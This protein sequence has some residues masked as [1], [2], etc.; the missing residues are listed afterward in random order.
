MAEVTTKPLPVV[1]TETDHQ[2]GI[3]AVRLASVVGRTTQLSDEARE[4]LEA[5]ER[6]ASE[7]LGQLWEE[8]AGT[9]DVA[10]KITKVRPTD[11]RPE[12]S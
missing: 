3:P 8:V 4:S 11:G 2:I 10:K 9:P 12:L 7:A 5:R 6:A 1:R